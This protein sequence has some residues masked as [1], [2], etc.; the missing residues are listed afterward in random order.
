MSKTLNAFIKTR[1]GPVPTP[2][3][4]LVEGVRITDELVFFFDILGERH[5]E[6]RESGENSDSS[7]ADAAFEILLDKALE[8]IQLLKDV[9]K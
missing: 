3:E 9:L 2:Q 8:K 7:K 5:P 4:L 6:F 1:A